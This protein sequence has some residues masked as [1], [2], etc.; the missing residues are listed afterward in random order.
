MR[1]DGTSA[2]PGQW[3]RRPDVIGVVRE[4]HLLPDQLSRRSGAV[5]LKDDES[6]KL[7]PQVSFSSY[8]EIMTNRA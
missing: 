2:P 1:I 4:T 7:T 8:A 5:C 6:V 3:Q